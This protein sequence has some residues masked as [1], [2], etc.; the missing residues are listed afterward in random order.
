MWAVF[1]ATD[2]LPIEM[3]FDYWWNLL[4]LTLIWAISRSD[5][6][7]F[8]WLYVEHV[9]LVH[10]GSI[11]RSIL[12][13]VRNRLWARILRISNLRDLRN[14]AN[15]ETWLSVDSQILNMIA[16]K[17]W[18]E[19]PRCTCIG[20]CC[21]VLLLKLQLLLQLFLLKSSLFQYLI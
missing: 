20:L 11:F 9:S 6:W 7:S 19:T 10:L 21:S 15:I 16:W 4:G 2:A 13:L 5:I 8:I 1:L 18:Q 12:D 17:H 3:C 14:F